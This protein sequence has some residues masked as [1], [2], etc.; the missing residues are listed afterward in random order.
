MEK[1]ILW[2]DP[3]KQ[4]IDPKLFSKTAEDLAK[5]INEDIRIARNSNKRTQIRKFYDE[6][7]RL[8]MLSKTRPDEEW[9]NILP[10]VHMLTA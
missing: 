6:V 4:T 7:V 5:K 1:I 3:E 10:L 8:N 2:K 9:D